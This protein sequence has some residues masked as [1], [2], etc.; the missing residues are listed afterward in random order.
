MTP[1]PTTPAKGHDEGSTTD[2]A[3]ATNPLLD[4]LKEAYFWCHQ[5]AGNEDGFP[6]Q[7]MLDNRVERLAQALKDAGVDPDS[8]TEDE[9]DEE[10]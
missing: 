10:A 7:E 2:Q 5:D 1:T 6:D 3:A 4:A 9:D 8:L